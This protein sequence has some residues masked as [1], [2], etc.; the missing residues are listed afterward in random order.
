ML[1]QW[2]YT[3]LALQFLSGLLRRDV[4]P[5]PDVARLFINNTLSPHPPLRATAQKSVRFSSHSGDRYF[6]HNSDRGVV[7]LLGII[8]IRTYSHTTTDLWLDE[9]RSPV[10]RH[11]S[12]RNDMQFHNYINKTPSTVDE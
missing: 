4:A 5:S 9:W 2:R 10:A 1:H 12:I 6:K 11:V 8:K 7:K 3:H